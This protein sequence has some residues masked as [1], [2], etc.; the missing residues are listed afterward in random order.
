M[1]YMAVRYEGLDSY[2]DLELTE[3]IPSRG[4]KEPIHGVLPILLK[5]HREDPVNEWEENRNNIKIL[6]VSL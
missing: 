1:F 3:L 4:D 5:W 6:I 2:P